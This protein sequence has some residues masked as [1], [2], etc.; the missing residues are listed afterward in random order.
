MTIMP[1]ISK[2]SY[3][4]ML[5]LALMPF[6]FSCNKS[7]NEIPPVIVEVKSEAMQ[8]MQHG[9]GLNAMAGAI[10][11]IE[12]TVSDDMAL[13]SMKC[14]FSTPS[15][16]HS[17]S[18]HE[19]GQIPAFRASNIGRWESDK[20]I[21]LDGVNAT[22]TLKFDLPDTISGAW[23]ILISVM[24][25]NGNLASYESSIIIQ[26]DSI[27]AIIPSAITPPA[28]ADGIV[29]LHVGE[30]M[31][32]EGNILD[33]DYLQQIS[34]KLYLDDTVVWQQVWTPENVWMFDLTQINIPNFNYPG[35]YK[36]RIDAVDRKGWSNWV[37]CL[38][39]VQ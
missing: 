4:L 26:N 14:A 28:N 25:A 7:A 9:D 23:D 34:A 16:N 24:D 11:R 5:P 33:G 36:L 32:A 21:A 20:F 13:K 27:P 2:N 37:V 35:N 8:G 3:F 12:V 6:L 31:I 15:E 22:E 17:H 19:D 18:V 1:P 30:S 39:E 29:K 38:V 10:A